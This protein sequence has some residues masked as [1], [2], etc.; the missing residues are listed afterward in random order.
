MGD[1]IEDENLHTYSTVVVIKGIC[2]KAK[3]T[4]CAAIGGPSTLPVDAC[5]LCSEEGEE[6]PAQRVSFSPPY[7]EGARTKSNICTKEA[8][9]TTVLH[10][11]PPIVHGLWRI[12]NAAQKL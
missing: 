2:V 6:Y 3:T 8:A 7:R 5:A 12:K 1:C 11:V 4:G 10:L 9:G